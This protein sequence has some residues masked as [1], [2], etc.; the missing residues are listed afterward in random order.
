MFPLVVKPVEKI[1]C[2]S[3]IRIFRDTLVP[4]EIRCGKIYR[5]EIQM[6]LIK[7]DNDRSW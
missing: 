1:I 5:A 6:A 4:E 7:N 3:D 2:N